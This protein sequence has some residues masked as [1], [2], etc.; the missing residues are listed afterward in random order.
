MVI[1]DP[2]A[3][4]DSAL[5]HS[6][7]VVSLT[8]E[9]SVLLSVASFLGGGGSVWQQLPPR[10]SLRMLLSLD[11]AQQATAFRRRLDPAMSGGGVQHVSIPRH[12]RSTGA[13][14]TSARPRVVGPHP[15]GQVDCEPETTGLRSHGPALVLQKTQRPSVPACR[16]GDGG[17][18][19]RVPVSETPFLSRWRGPKDCVELAGRQDLRFAPIRP[20]D[21]DLSAWS[22]GSCL[23]LETGHYD[24]CVDDHMQSIKSGTRYHE[25]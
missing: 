18:A 24:A 13:W 4:C 1:L 12:V 6:P 14:R 8:E 7:F 10:T 5:V 3:R 23:L 17:P 19:S 2:S 15:R 25:V 20:D 22:S 16:F 9:G 21:R 11:V